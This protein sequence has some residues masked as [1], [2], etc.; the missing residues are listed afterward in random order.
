MKLLSLWFCICLH[1]QKV[2]LVVASLVYLILGY[3][4]SSY[5]LAESINMTAVYEQSSICKRRSQEHNG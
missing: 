3:L 5:H 2:L 1:L 4:S